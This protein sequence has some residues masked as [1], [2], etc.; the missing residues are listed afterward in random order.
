MANLLF[1]SFILLKVGNITLWVTDVIVFAGNCD[2]DSALL[3]KPSCAAE[4]NF[5]II[6][7]NEFM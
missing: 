2:K 6:I 3:Y 1:S 4:K 5:P 7:G